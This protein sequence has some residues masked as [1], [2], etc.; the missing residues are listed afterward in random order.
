MKV[1]RFL[2]TE[3]R[4]ILAEAEE[5]GVESVCRR[6][7]I[8]EHTLHRWRARYA[9]TFND[10][11]PDDWSRIAQL[12]EENARLKRLLSKQAVDIAML[13]GTLSRRTG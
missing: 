7:S 10:V 4:A 6:Y 12:R 13:R 5:H 2:E 11:R 8:S 9:A 1:K 3:I